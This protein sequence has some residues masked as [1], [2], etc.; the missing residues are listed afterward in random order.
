MGHR[1]VRILYLNVPAS[2]LGLRLWL[3][4][5]FFNKAESHHPNE[6][7]SHPARVSSGSDRIAQHALSVTGYNVA[8]LSLSS[9]CCASVT[10]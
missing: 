4:L 6:R 5:A 9:M 2:A 10:Q 1:P 7:E 3:A 8:R